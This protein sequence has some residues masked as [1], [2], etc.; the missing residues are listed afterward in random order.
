LLGTCNAAAAP[1]AP[2]EQVRR[3]PQ[4][5][6]CVSGFCSI[7]I[8]DDVGLPCK[9]TNCHLA[10]RSCQSAAMPLLI[11]V[12]GVLVVLLLLLLLLLVLE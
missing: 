2:G 8:A 12:I 1:A 5:T 10:A 3:I 6:V 9:A 7:S 4:D 11:V